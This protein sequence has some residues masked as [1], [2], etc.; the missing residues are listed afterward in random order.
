MPAKLPPGESAR[1]KAAR[2]G[3]WYKENRETLKAKRRVYRLKNVKRFRAKAIKNYYDKRHTPRQ[4]ARQI[5]RSSKVRA[6]Q[7]GREFSLSF[8]KVLAAIESGFCEAT[9]LPFDMHHAK[10]RSPFAPSLD[11]KDNSKGY[12]DG[13]TRVVVWALNM[14]CGDYGEEVLWQVVKARWPDRIK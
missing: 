13:N 1:R 8:S 14:A 12:T 9:G 2:Y 7:A 10:G 3:A 11:R 4:R 5:W 6:L